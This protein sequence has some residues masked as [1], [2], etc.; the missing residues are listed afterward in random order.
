LGPTLHGIRFARS[1]G[2]ANAQP[3]GEDLV[4]A[5]WGLRATNG[6][7]SRIAERVSVSL[8]TLPSIRASDCTYE[9]R[10]R[11]PGLSPLGVERQRQ[12]L[13]RIPYVEKM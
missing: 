10:D 13:L 1:R 7:H 8:I 3:L 2:P 12:R 5:G 6:K 11:F 9:E 4:R